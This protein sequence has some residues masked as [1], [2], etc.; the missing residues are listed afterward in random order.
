MDSVE[1]SYKRLDR[2]LTSSINL[3]PSVEQDL[4]NL[5]EMWAARSLDEGLAVSRSMSPTPH[6]YDFGVVTGDARYLADQGEL[7]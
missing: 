4:T 6:W 5:I 3:P 1:S 7:T 2:L